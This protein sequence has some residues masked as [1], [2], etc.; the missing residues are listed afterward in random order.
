MVVCLFYDVVQPPVIF[1]TSSSLAA[2]MSAGNDIEQRIY[3]LMAD[4]DGILG[5]NPSY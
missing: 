5:L 2:L 4:P 1:V 3:T